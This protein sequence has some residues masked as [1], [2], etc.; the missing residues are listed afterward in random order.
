MVIGSDSEKESKKGIKKEIKK[1]IKP[2]FKQ[3]VKDEFKDEFKPKKEKTESLDNGSSIPHT[4]PEAPQDGENGGGDND[5]CL[6]CTT[7]QPNGYVPV[8]NSAGASQPANYP[9][10]EIHSFD[11]ATNMNFHPQTMIATTSE[12]LEL[13]DFAGSAWL[14]H[15]ESQHFYWGMVPHETSENGH[16]A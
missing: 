11:Y 6:L 5:L 7:E 3:E 9:I 1:E 16:Q 15:P 2:E 14:P 8:V 10:A 13:N 4:I 12:G